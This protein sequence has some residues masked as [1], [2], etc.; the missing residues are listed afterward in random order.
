MFSST[1]LVTQPIFCDATMRIA[2]VSYLLGV[3]LV[4]L[5]GLKSTTLISSPHHHGAGGVSRFVLLL[6]DVAFKLNNAVPY[7]DAG[8]RGQEKARSVVMFN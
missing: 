6:N 8:S 7:P 3:L 4:W 2:V 1:Y 5:P